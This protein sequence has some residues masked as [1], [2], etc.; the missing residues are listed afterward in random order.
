M[1][2]PQVPDEH[3]YWLGRVTAAY[4]MLDVQIGMLAHAALTGENWTEDWAGVAG[5]PGL[6]VQLCQGALPRMPDDLAD[7]ARA[8]LEAAQP[9][10]LRRHQ[11]SHSVF[12]LDPESAGPTAPWVLKDPK[13]PERPLLYE[14][15][16]AELV[17]AINALSRTAG[18]LR[19]E[20]KQSKKDR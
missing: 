17:R 12:V 5:R 9:L 20:L 3:Y 7:R 15:E 8:L 18:Q 13:G 14:D 2:A 1:T 6:A 19:A 11:L 16:G 10:R 4:G